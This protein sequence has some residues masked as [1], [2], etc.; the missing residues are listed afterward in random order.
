[1]KKYLFWTTVALLL[2]FLATARQNEEKARLIILAD[3][4]NEPDEEQ[5]MMHM[6]MCSNE[7]TLEG[8][9]AVTGKY[10]HPDHPTPFKRKVHPELFLKLI[11]GYERVWQNLSKHAKGYPDPDYLRSIVLPGQA[12]YGIADTGEGKTSEGSRLIER[13]LEKEDPRPVYV[14]VNAGSN[15]LAQALKD[16]EKSHSE[17][18]LEEAVAKLR[19]F[20]NGAQDNSGAWICH[21]FPGIHWIRSNYQTYCYGGPSWEGA[22]DG[23]GK[24][25]ELGPYT[26]EPYDYSPL[27][28]HQWA[29]EHIV[30]NHGPFG[31]YWPL[32]TFHGGKIGFLE[33]GGTI[34]WLGF[35]STGLS[36]LDRPWW[37][38]WSGRFSREKVKNDWSRHESV[39]VDEVACDPFYTYAEGEDTWTDPASG[40]TYKGNF[41]PVWRWRRAFFNDFRCRMDWCYMTYDEANHAPV[42]LVNGDMSDRIIHMDA[43]PGDKIYLDAEGTSD[44]DGDLFAIHWWCYGEAGTYEGLPVISNR[45]AEKA[46]VEIPEDAAGSEIHIILEV[47]DLS[48]IA[49]LWDYRRIVISVSNE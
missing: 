22:I 31:P 27:G 18:E 21:R 35:V 6:L 30:G 9:I 40:E 45:S 23:T 17:K 3:M 10:L 1:M 42:A 28:Q 46:L 19:V 5:Q 36:D 4:G 48:D 15:T 34:P 32:R 47:K 43:G 26:W 20:E 16:Y 38:G 49:S 11:E 39:R 33:G 41:V 37:G 25:I 44:P 13:A 24:D 2:P 7:F 14:V 29:L 8:L 12:G